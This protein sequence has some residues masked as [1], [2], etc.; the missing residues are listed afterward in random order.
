MADKTKNILN[1]RSKLRKYFYRNGQRES[2]RDKV[3]EQS[4]ECTREIL[5]AKKTVYS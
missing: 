4:A 1:E 5:E 2:D 3:L